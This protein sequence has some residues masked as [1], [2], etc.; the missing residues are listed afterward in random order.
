[1]TESPVV[2]EFV[3]L[4]GAGKTTLARRVAERLEAEGRSCHAPRFGR[5]ASVRR[6]RLERALQLTSTY[7]TMGGLSVEV[8][9]FGLAI[10]PLRPGRV[11]W[12]RELL[13]SVQSIVAAES[14]SDFVLL[15]QGFL[16][17]AWSATV[18]GTLPSPPVIE[19]LVRRAAA[20]HGYRVIYIHLVVES[21]TA[22]DRIAGRQ[23][24]RSRFDRIPRSDAA[25]LLAELRG[26]LDGI[27]GCAARATTSPVLRLD[28]R[29]SVEELTDTVV[30]FL[31]GARVERVG[32]RSGGPAGG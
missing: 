8:L 16:Q 27:V 29:A 28:G 1:M 17:A 20:F 11:R 24:G 22:L 21:G 25:D 15:D 9:R 5:P 2:L 30:E 13:D 7:A 14:G 12:L 4:P 19:R 23:G 31:T 32:S 18:H 3:G 10:R 6:S 26:R